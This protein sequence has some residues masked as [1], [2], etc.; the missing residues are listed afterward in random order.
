MT[1]AFTIG[2]RVTFD[3]YTELE[4]ELRHRLSVLSTQLE[5]SDR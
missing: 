3:S 2:I 4:V 1:D 5:S